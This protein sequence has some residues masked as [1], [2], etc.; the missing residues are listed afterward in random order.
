MTLRFGY[1]PHRDCLFT[2]PHDLLF[3]FASATQ[4]AGIGLRQNNGQ[5]E[6]LGKGLW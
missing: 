6:E 5:A 2:I 3:L 1:E 4:G